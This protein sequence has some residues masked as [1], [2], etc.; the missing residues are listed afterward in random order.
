V[1][2]PGQDR[3]TFTGNLTNGSAATFDAGTQPPQDPFLMVRRVWN[4]G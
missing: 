4:P 1:S 3:T 2:I